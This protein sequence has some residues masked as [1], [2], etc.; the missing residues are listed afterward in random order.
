AEAL[1]HELHM[2]LIGFQIAPLVDH[3]HLPRPIV[4]IDPMRRGKIQQMRLGVFCQVEQR[5]CAREAD[6]AFQFFAPCALPC[7]QLAAIAPGCAI[8]ET[9]SIDQRHA[10]SGL[11]KMR[12]CRQPREAAADDDDIDRKVAIKWLDRKSTR[13]NSSHV[14]ISY[15]DFCL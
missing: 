6:L 9:M 5:L 11:R 4:D 15:A 8:A 12:G 3:G 1:S 7:A 2:G 13:L 10:G 14:K